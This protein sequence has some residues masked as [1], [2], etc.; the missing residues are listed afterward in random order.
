M[1]NWRND[2]T[3]FNRHITEQMQIRAQGTGLDVLSVDI[4]LTPHSTPGEVITDNEFIVNVYMARSGVQEKARGSLY[5][6]WKLV[7]A[8][9]GKT[10]VEMLFC[11]AERGFEYFTGQRKPCSMVRQ[12]VGV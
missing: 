1:K 3:E 2:I 9:K 12:A 6:S 7:N 5:I 4:P 8:V 10:F 11:M